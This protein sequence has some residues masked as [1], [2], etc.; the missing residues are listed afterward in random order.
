MLFE[1]CNEP[2]IKPV[3]WSE[4]HEATR[5]VIRASNPHRTLI[6]GCVYGNRIKYLKD[7][8][9]PDDDP[10][11]I[12]AIHY[13][14]PIQFTHQGAPWSSKGRDQKDVPWTA[15]VEEQ[16]AVVREFDQ[17]QQWSRENNRP[18]T[19]GEF[20]A[21]A[22]AAMKYRRIWTDFISRQAEISGLEVELLAV[23]R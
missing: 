6:I 14:E 12:V 1:L 16:A 5:R 11:I 22:K 18:L 3:I 2:N 7:L 8:M 21:Y 20:G 4:L 9:L 23:R 15:T 17:A 13:Y 10:G 19:L